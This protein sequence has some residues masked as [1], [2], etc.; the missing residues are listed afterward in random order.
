[1]GNVALNDQLHHVTSFIALEILSLK[2]QDKQLTAEENQN[3]CS[4]HKT[5]L[6]NELMMAVENNRNV[7]AVVVVVVEGKQ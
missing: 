5:L 3:C 6:Q 1:M 4:L 7:V 2:Q